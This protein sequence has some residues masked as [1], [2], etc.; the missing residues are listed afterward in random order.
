MKAEKKEV[1]SSASKPLRRFGRAT[2]CQLNNMAYLHHNQLKELTG[3]DREIE[4]IRSNNGSRTTSQN[5]L[6]S[7][8]KQE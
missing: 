7:Q 5:R 4:R 8:I 6:V 1:S 2:K 3:L